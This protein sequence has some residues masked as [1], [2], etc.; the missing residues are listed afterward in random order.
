MSYDLSRKNITVEKELEGVPKVSID[1]CQ[2]QQVFIN[3][4][5]NAQQAMYPGGGVLEIRLQ[6]IGAKA[7]GDEG[8]KDLAHGTAHG[9][10]H[11]T[12][13]GTDDGIVGYVEISVRDSGR[14]I[15]RDDLPHIFDPF[16]STKGVYARNESEKEQQ[17]T[18]L[19]LALCY[20]IIS[21]HNG[22]ITA[23]SKPWRGSTFIIRLPV[24]D[25]KQEHLGQRECEQSETPESNC[26][27]LE[28]ISILVVDD[29]E[30]IVE[31]I[32][33]YLESLKAKVSSASNGERALSILGAAERPFDLVL[34]DILM[35]GSSGLTLLQRIR[36]A[37]MA[38]KVLLLTGKFTEEISFI[39]HQ[40]GA[41]GCV[42]KPI[43]LAELLETIKKIL[44][45]P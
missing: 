33:G 26:S 6:Y 27:S 15:S 16:F 38:R 9:T 39:A 37:G 36:K 43:K 31:Q 1:A 22:S 28:G 11:G 7:R 44:S 25:S 32:C 17:G 12:D 13:D 14:G 3:L 23:E 29:E 34:S 40:S 20:G 35:P 8:V 2:I 21:N 41:D 19:G 30:E 4:F 10:G 45:T 42:S 24:V 18:G 5:K